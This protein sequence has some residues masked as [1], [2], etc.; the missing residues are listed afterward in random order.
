MSVS[1]VLKSQAKGTILQNHGVFTE[2]KF[3]LNQS[4]LVTL[5]FKPIKIIVSL[6]LI[7]TRI[8]SK[9]E[10]SEAINNVAMNH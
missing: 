8:S 10:Y 5:F 1:S 6:S 9:T 2:I 7:I 3:V 4:N